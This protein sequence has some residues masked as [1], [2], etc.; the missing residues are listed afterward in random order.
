MPSRRSLI[1]S[2]P[3]LLSTTITSLSSESST[4][5]DSLAI[6]LWNDCRLESLY[7]LYSP[8]VV[9]LAAGNL[10]TETYAQ[11][12]FQ[13]IA[14]G[15]TAVT[16]SEKAEND[17]DDP[18]AKAIFAMFK[19]GD[20]SGVESSQAWL[21]E[22][23]PDADSDYVV[24][25][26]T[27]YY[28][29]FL[30]DT[31]N[32]IVEGHDEQFT[33]PIVS[34]FTLAAMIPCWKLYF[35]IGKQVVASIGDYYKNPYRDWIDGNS[36]D[37]LGEEIKTIE[38]VLNKLAASLG[39]TSE[40]LDI[41]E[42]VYRKGMKCEIQFFHAQ[43]FFQQTS[44]PV[45]G[46]LSKTGERLLILSNYDGTANVVDSSAVLADLAVSSKAE[47]KA[48]WSHL[49]AQYKEEYE[50]EVDLISNSVKTEFSYD[51]VVQAL[52]PFSG[53]EVELTD[54]N[55]HANQ[56]GFEGS[57]TTGEIIGKVVSPQ[58]KVDTFDEILKT[59]NGD[60]DTKTLA[61]YVGESVEDL[62]CLLKANIGIVIGS[63]S[64]LKRVATQL[65]V[66]F[67]P[68]FAASID[69]QVDNIGSWT[70]LTGTLYTVSSWSEIN[71]FVLGWQK[72]L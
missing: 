24:N 51:A 46:Q 29:Q 63:S 7:A 49:F 47:M 36:D 62:L 34:V 39:L 20:Q 43:P 52:E 58:D 71:T 56:L 61:V 72:K 65:G 32:G 69:K 26:A 12:I 38:S 40:Q 15:K 21:D 55:V 13:D 10:D 67:K 54:V 18:D 17:T 48:K 23:R 9:S 8:F 2:V 3:Y 53:I 28:Q 35:F 25:D 1:S 42:E 37:S 68:L 4:E 33:G 41:V 59:T 60:N 66:T 45:I 31:V 5:E 30:I 22:H 44:V 16:V 27:K 64:S 19:E 57:V 50:Q 11:Y 6:R 70:G 14:Y